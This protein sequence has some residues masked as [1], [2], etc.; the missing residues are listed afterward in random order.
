MS[1]ILNFTHNGITAMHTPA[2]QALGALSVDV[3]AIV[4]TA[5][6]ADA[7]IFP[8][9]KP[10]RISKITEAAKLDTTGAGKGFLVHAC[11]KTF[12]QV[13]APIYVIRVAEGA[14]EAETIQ[15]VI[16]GINV[17][18]GQKTGI[19]AISNCLEKPTLIAAPGYSHNAGVANAL[20]A[21]S[22]SIKARFICDLVGVKAADLIANVN[23]FGGKDLGFDACIALA[24][25]ARYTNGRGTLTMPASVVALGAIASK[26]PWL[27]I[28]HTGVAIDGVDI[29]FDYNTLDSST[30]GNLLNKHGICYFGNTS[31]GG[32]SLI[33]NRTITGRF[34]AHV[35]LEH[36]LT[37]KLVAAMEPALGKRLTKT[38][39]EQ[40]V[41]R[42]NNWLESLIAEEVVMPGSRCYLHPEKN[43]VDNYTSGRWF[44]VVEYAGYG[45]NENTVI[46]LVESNGI[47]ESFLGSVL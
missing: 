35:G 16:G 24:H 34:A 29:Y 37:R 25:T 33:G 5:P 22:K 8:L 43:T 19:K 2:P 41:N 3:I 46:E 9:N 4:G 28:G 18:T 10:V 11:E 7:T 20:A 21:M 40:Q 30:E 15:S 12:E 26:S 32:W 44:I 6:D 38:F 27:G 47:V 13:R 1:E 45:I 42:V 23:Q 17:D 14:N 39:M 36:A 31:A